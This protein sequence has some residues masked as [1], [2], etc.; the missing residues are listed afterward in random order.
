MTESA[1]VREV[2]V[3]IREVPMRS[4]SDTACLRFND[5]SPSLE[6]WSI[7][8]VPTDGAVASVRSARAGR[9]AGSDIWTP[10]EGRVET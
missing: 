9:S 8:D 10:P 3:P 2:E 7:V 4:T 1:M 5:L 6:R